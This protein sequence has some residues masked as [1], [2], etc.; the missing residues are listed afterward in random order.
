MNTPRR[1]TNNNGAVIVPVPTILFHTLPEEDAEE[2]DRE[3]IDDEDNIQLVE[4]APQQEEETILEED[5]SSN[6][7]DDKDSSYYGVGDEE[8][9]D[10]GSDYYFSLPSNAVSAS[11]SSAINYY[12]EM[13]VTDESNEVFSFEEDGSIIAM[14]N[15]EGQ[16]E[17]SMHDVEYHLN[18]VASTTMESETAGA[19]AS[20]MNEMTATPSAPVTLMGSIWVPHP[21]HG[22]VRRS[23][24]LLAR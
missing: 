4:C 5:L 16:E 18:E 17:N 7:A 11:S 14:D 23:A 8:E 6:V 2:M 9:K 1:T 19:G 15:E 13:G 3:P 24:R 21:T 22:I 20:V 12:T 10:D